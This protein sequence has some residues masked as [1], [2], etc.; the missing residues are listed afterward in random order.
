[1]RD[2]DPRP[3]SQLLSPLSAVCPLLLFT[4]NTNHEGFV[5]AMSTLTSIIGNLVDYPDEPKYK[6]LRLT[7]ATLKSRLFSHAGG[8]AAVKCVE[9][10][11]EGQQSL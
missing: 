11:R 1:M 10:R 3:C 8:V 5:T 4:R 6:R 7:N 9:R 2:R